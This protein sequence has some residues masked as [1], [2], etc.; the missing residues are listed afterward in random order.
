MEGRA[1][2]GAEP[3]GGSRARGNPGSAGLS[4]D[5]SELRVPGFAAQVS[6]S[7]G[8]EGWRPKSVWPL[9]KGD[10]C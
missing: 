10:E 4:S 7:I 8:H 2:S 5:L 6:A 3:R 1:G 9:G